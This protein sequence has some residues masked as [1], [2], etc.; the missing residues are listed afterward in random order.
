MAYDDLNI[1]IDSAIVL[2]KKGLLLAKELKD[3]SEIAKAHNNLGSMY[4]NIEDNVSAI[5]QFQQ[6]IEIYKSINEVKDIS[7]PINNLGVLYYYSKNFG[8]AAQYFKESYDLD[9]KNKVSSD[10]LMVDY[11]NLAATY[12]EKVDLDSSLYYNEKAFQLAD[13]TNN[14]YRKIS[15]LIALGR[16]FAIKGDY[17]KANTNFLKAIKTVDSSSSK[18]NVAALYINYG[19]FLHAKLN[20]PKK[21]LHYFK[22][23]YNFSKK[24][25]LKKRIVDVDNAF[26]RH[27]EK[28]KNHK[29]IAEWQK[30]YIAD[31]WS[32]DSLRQTKRV[33]ELEA[34]YELETKQKNIEKGKV[35]VLEL[36]LKNKEVIK[37]RNRLIALAFILLFSGLLASFLY[38]KK[39]EYSDVL[40]RKNKLIENQKNNLELSNNKLIK[41]N[42]NLQVIK[43]DLLSEKSDLISN[44]KSLISKIAAFQL[45]N[46]IIE[47]DGILVNI[48]DIYKISTFDDINKKDVVNMQIIDENKIIKDQPIY[49]SLASVINLMEEYSIPSIVRISGSEIINLRFL[50]KDKSCNKWEF[51]YKHNS[52]TSEKIIVKRTFTED[53]SKTYDEYLSKY[54]HVD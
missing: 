31:K 28:L 53:F 52:N 34:K 10:D 16:L 29:K 30:K 17:S 47:I 7:S 5:Q 23:A 46:S 4:Q 32:L 37:T 36:K 41:H 8:K 50:T 44:K 13:S 51:K 48:S 2:Q 12:E 54:K 42:N 14:N 39:K 9:K 11:L 20:N 26:V 24:Y 25:D 6:S 49:M 19:A 21:G 22:K 40:L 18:N 15:S 33:D 35:K 45:E 43:R 27:Y 1:K 3:T 38:K